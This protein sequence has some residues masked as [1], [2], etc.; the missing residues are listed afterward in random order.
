MD[1]FSKVHNESEC[2]FCS[3]F[4]CHHTVSFLGAG[5]NDNLFERP[6]PNAK[7]DLFIM[8]SFSRDRACDVLFCLFGWQKMWLTAWFVS[9]MGTVY[10]VPQWF[11]FL[12]PSRLGEVR[13]VWN[14]GCQNFLV[15]KCGMLRLVWDGRILLNNI[16]LTGFSG[17]IEASQ[18]LTRRK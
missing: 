11:S 9:G 1:R 10:P 5:G 13:S 7:K 6:T 3:I 12:V 17:Y 14:R 2:A 4:H 8:V 18:L 15:L 16:H